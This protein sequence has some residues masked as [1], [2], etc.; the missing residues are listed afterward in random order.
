VSAGPE[1][2]S[3]RAWLE[4]QPGLAV[5]VAGRLEALPLGR[6]DLIWIHG[7]RAEPERDLTGWLQ[8][9]GRLLLSL[10]AVN[11]PVRMGLDQAAPDEWHDGPWQ[12]AADEVPPPDSRSFPAFPHLRG[13]AAFGPHPLFRGLDRGVFTWAPTEGEPCRW[14]VYRARRPARGAGVAVERTPFAVNPDRLVAWEYA[15]GEGGILCLGAFVYLA[16]RAGLQSAQLRALL[17]NAIG[18]DAVPHASRSGTASHWPAGGTG[19]DHADEPPA[20]PILA[21]APG[22]VWDEWTPSA[23]P[24]LIEST[25]RANHPFTLAGR[26]VLVI[27]GER[28]GP[29]EVWVHPFR[30]LCAA[31]LLVNGRVPEAVSVRIAPDEI[32]RIVR[33]GNTELTERLTTSLDHGLV[34]WSAVADSPVAISLEWTTDLRRMWPYPPPLEGASVVRQSPSAIR[35]GL[36]GE[37]Q[38]VEVRA[39]TG[40]LGTPAATVAGDGVRVE[41][42]GER[43][44]RVVIAAGADEAEL[45]RAL[46]ALRRRKLRGIR[47]ER[48]LHARRLEERLARLETPDAALNR[49]FG[50]AKVRLDSF[51]AEAPG[52]GRSLAAGFGP[53][54]SGG[55]AGRPGYAWFFGRDACWSAFASLAM[56]DREIARDVLR[57]LARTQ[58]AS[59]KV[60]Q[61]YTTSGLASYDAADTTPLFL[62]LAARYAAWSGDLETL[63]GLWSPIL[64][65]YR[66]CLGTDHD[67]DGLLENG[68]VGHGWIE[69][70]PLSG[71]HVELYVAACWLAALEGLAPVAHALGFEPLAEELV[72]RG[73][74][75]RDS[76]RRRFHADGDYACG[77]DGDGRPRMQ[78]SALL[79][80]PLLLGAV[81]GREVPTWFESIAGDG[82]TTPWGVRL[83][84]ADD[85]RFDPQGIHRG[86]VW[87]LY[88]GWVSLAEWRAGRWESALAHLKSNASLAAER[89]K[90]AFDESLH[91]LERVG[92]GC[93]DQA[94]SAAMVI[95]PVI[96][97][98]WGV[99]PDALNHTVQVSPYL[100]QGWNEMA[101]RR[102]RVGPT[103]LDLRLRRRPGR[104]RLG[105]ARVH[106]P[107]IRFAATVRSPS[108]LDHITLD[109]DPLGG[110]RA[111]FEA[112][113]EHELEFGLRDP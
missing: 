5:T 31:R 110:S 14:L 90:G 21:A 46:D 6:T 108:P 111:V 17:S 9:G 13:L 36:A 43:I 39:V 24:L 113:A 74:Q 48:L 97:G 103:T 32:V 73:V 107:R 53:S 15:V 22:D 109:D 88:T 27:G 91:G 1:G 49:G 85:P 47:Q 37:S 87:P 40:T 18:G 84:A 42:R 105:V 20:T 76:I 61:E 106:G 77:L 102:L 71:L 28:T 65:A 79:A 59:G 56:G 89:A 2:V 92:T 41:A 4:S 99:V 78:R 30:A 62:L 93:P 95:S 63:A 96:E 58:D 3:A 26:R 44:L 94:G 7:V 80:V 10:E 29:G 25:A 54:A 86:T 67:G 70:G 45:D 8:A 52:V 75:A 34:F 35:I 11:L 83:L 104:L 100:P 82:F 112:S 12:D 16:A 101:L 55:A 81:D 66:F 68:G 57:F 98:L 50:W 38:A 33:A 23:S 60:A 64:T 69:H 51:L 72:A 19:R